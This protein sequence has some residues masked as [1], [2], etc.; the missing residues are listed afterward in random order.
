MKV[1]LTDDGDSRL[2][3]SFNIHELHEKKRERRER[4][5]KQYKQVG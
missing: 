3:E 5:V 4:E 1:T 2:V